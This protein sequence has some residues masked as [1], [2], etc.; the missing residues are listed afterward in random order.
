MECFS[1]SG[2]AMVANGTCQNA[3]YPGILNAWSVMDISFMKPIMTFLNE[4]IAKT[5]E[6][7]TNTMLDTAT[8]NQSVS[9]VSASITAVNQTVN[10]AVLTISNMD[11]TMRNIAVNM[12]RIHN[13]IYGD[14]ISRVVIGNDMTDPAVIQQTLNDCSAMFSTVMAISII[15][16]IVLVGMI[17][18]FIVLYN[19]T[20]KINGKI[21]ELADRLNSGGLKVP[22]EVPEQKVAWPDNTIYPDTSDIDT[23][24]YTD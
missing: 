20:M 4:S 15:L 10:T 6:N 3:T 7:M 22:T 24:S 23:V 21:S 11:Q 18:G 1:W 8:L 19:R 9:N 13:A 14:T 12:S 2:S 16:G 5:Y 17:V